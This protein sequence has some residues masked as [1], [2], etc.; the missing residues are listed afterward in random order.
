MNNNAIAVLGQY[1]SY[2]ADT[3]ASYT[4]RYDTSPIGLSD[5]GGIDIDTTNKRL[6]VSD[7]ANNRI[8]VFS[9]NADN[10]IASK[11]PVNVLGQSDMFS[12]S[13]GLTQSKLNVPSEVAF[14]SSNNRLFV[15][16]TNNNRVLIYNTATI[17]DG[18]GASIVLGQPDFTSNTAATTQSGMSAPNGLAYNSAQSILY[19]SDVNNN[20][21]LVFNVANPGNGMNASNVL[22]QSSFTTS[23][24][25]TTQS[26]MDTPLGLAYKA[27]TTQLFVADFANNRVLVYNTSSVANGM[28]ASNVIGQVNFTSNV[29]DTNPPNSGASASG[30]ANPRDVAVD[31]SGNT[32]AVADQIN[33]RVL[34]YNLS[35]L[36]DGMNASNV[37]GQSN[38]TGYTAAT[39][40]SRL[41]FP[42]YVMFSSSTNRLFVSDSGNHRI[43]LFNTGSI[44][45]GMNASDLIGH[46]GSASATTTVSYTK[47]GINN[48]PHERSLTS[49]PI[50]PEGVSNVLIDNV[51]HRAFV[52]NVYS[53]RILVY[54]LDANDNP[55]DLTAD[56]VLGTTDFTGTASGSAGRFINPHQTAFDASTN[57]LYVTDSGQNRVLVFDVSTITNG[58]GAIYVLGQPDFTTT[59]TATTQAGM[60]YPEG[61]EID[62]AAKRLF[63]ADSGNNRVLVFDV[64]TITNGENAVNVIGQPDFITSTIITPPTQNSLRYPTGIAYDG[65]SDRVFVADF[66]NT[67]ILVFNTAGI[68]NGM[69]ASNVIGQSVYTTTNSGTTQSRFSSTGSYNLDVDES[70]NRLFAADVYNSRIPVFDISS[71]SNGMAARTVIGQTNFTTGTSGISQSKL[72]YPQGVSYNGANRALWIADS[73]NNRVVVY[74]TWGY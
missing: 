65:I 9:L 7:S 34:L 42:R 3:S 55:V 44:T 54:N 23:A 14:D 50:Q 53:G 22:G 71:I 1:A 69:A 12:N 29:S 57:L 5:P 59:G 60:N 73:R 70:G 19:V 74:S 26:G 46:Y 17:A 45:N 8:L 43:L 52:T 30:L 2:P 64:T 48:T 16:D 10:T 56:Y 25:A 20:R 49:E 63:V 37:I 47:R 51:Y 28:N 33:D 35:S 36:A 32:L 21:I 39:S 67:R 4:K 15:A 18:M 27:T 38:F 61:I 13:Q 68:S 62:T 31:S 11:V 72:F 40:Q 41:R 6:F 58:E 66:S 24:A